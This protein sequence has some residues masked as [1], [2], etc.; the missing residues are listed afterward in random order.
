MIEPA[1]LCT[2]IPVRSVSHGLELITTAPTG[3]VELRLD[4]L[5]SN[6]PEAI[7]GAGLKL[8]DEAEDRGLSVIATVRSRSEGGL[9]QGSP[10]VAVKALALIESSGIR[11][12]YEAL[13]SWAPESCDACVASAHLSKPREETAVE[14]VKRARRMNASAAKVVFM[15]GSPRAAALAAKLVTHW[16]GWLTSFT[17]GELGV[18]SRVVAL[19][20]G[21]PFIFVSHH[22][23]PLRGVPLLS[24]IITHLPAEGGVLP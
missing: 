6:N 13:K 21:A 24:D 22:R 11:V 9:F 8:A 2:V 18:C 12:D 7:A 10:E 4:F 19:E 16:S 1:R 15:D 20:L 14:L 3:C 5:G 17:V 23:D